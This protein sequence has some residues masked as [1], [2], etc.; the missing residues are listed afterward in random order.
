MGRSV[1]Y[2]RRGGRSLKDQTKAQLTQVSIGHHN[3]GLAAAHA[4]TPQA[5][6]SPE[7]RPFL[8]GVLR[9]EHDGVFLLRFCFEQHQRDYST[10][11]LDWKHQQR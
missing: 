8:K 10:L 5:W 6:R 7:T 4:M 1:E 2:N 9:W 11:D 3:A